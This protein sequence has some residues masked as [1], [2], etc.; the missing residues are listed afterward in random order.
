MNHFGVV[1]HHLDGWLVWQGL[2]K[3]H[4]QVR[5][6]ILAFAYVQKLKDAE[7]VVVCLLK[8]RQVLDKYLFHIT[9][10]FGRFGAHH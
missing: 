8:L 3:E 9:D 4:G 2:Y 10:I 6:H 1:K 5:Q 7:V